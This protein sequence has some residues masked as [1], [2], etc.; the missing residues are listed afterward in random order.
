MGACPTRCRTG[1][2][3][4]G[5]AVGCIHSGFPPTYIIHGMLDDVVPVEHASIL[6]HALADHGV[7][8]K[9]WIVPGAKNNF[10]KGFNTM[11]DGW[12][13]DAAWFCLDAIGG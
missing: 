3:A 11:A 6:E 2:R 1:H 10:G 12:L 13:E 7:L 8:H 5:E 9:L 4:G